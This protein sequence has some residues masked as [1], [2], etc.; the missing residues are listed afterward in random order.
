MAAQIKEAG[1][2][3]SWIPELVQPAVEAYCKHYDNTRRQAAW[4]FFG[5][6]LAS[7]FFLASLLFSGARIIM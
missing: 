7:L 5:V 2:E 4:I 6:L 1:P 3:P